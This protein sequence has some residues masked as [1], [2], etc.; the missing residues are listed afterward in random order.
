MI[1]CLQA[2]VSIDGCDGEDDTSTARHCKT[3]QDEMKRSV[4]NDSVLDDRMMRTMSA[5]RSIMSTK[6]L[7]DILA[8][9]PA[10]QLDKQ[11]D[12][13]LIFFFLKL[14]VHENYFGT[15]NLLI[16]HN[17]PSMYQLSR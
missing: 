7:L 4:P 14:P 3:M 8:D 11:V 15:V 12:Y 10:L 6:P 17:V 13:L 2:E 16:W 1:C 5:R 9:Y